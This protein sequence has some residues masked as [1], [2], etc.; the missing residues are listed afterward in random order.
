MLALLMFLVVGRGLLV[1]ASAHS[2]F[3]HLTNGSVLSGKVLTKLSSEAGLCATVTG[4][5]YDNSS[6]MLSHYFLYVVAIRT[7]GGSNVGDLW[8][9]LDVCTMYVLS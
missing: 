4:I 7:E 9:S 1:D 8:W 3:H 6:N 5:L 2:F